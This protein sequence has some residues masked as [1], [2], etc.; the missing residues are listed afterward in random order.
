MIETADPDAGTTIV[1]FTTPGFAILGKVVQV[2][3]V[4]E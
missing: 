3:R 1:D 4:L 2:I